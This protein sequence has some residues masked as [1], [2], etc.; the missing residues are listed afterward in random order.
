MRDRID[1]LTTAGGSQADVVVVTFTKERNLAG[2]QRRFAEPFKVVT[3]PELELYHALG[4]NRGSVWRVY[5]LRAIRRYIT[6]LRGGAKMSRSTEDTLQLGGNA[7]VDHHGNLHWRFAGAG[8]D[9]RPS[10]DEIIASL[11]QIEL[12]QID[13]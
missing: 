3:D 4:F 7:I 2:Y 10:L 11:R 13:F 12:R 1:E 9:D 8:P 6:L 5:G